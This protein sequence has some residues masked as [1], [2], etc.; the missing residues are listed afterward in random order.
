MIDPK[1]PLVLVLRSSASLGSLT[2]YRSSIQSCLFTIQS[3]ATTI[4]MT[5]QGVFLMGAFCAAFEIQ[6]RLQPKLEETV[7][8]RPSPTGLSIEMRSGRSLYSRNHLATTQ[9]SGI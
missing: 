8:Y 7:E 2:L 6:P 3:L 1:I 5:Y 9:T 4:R